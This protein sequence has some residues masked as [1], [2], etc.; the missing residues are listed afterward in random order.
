MWAELMRNGPGL[1]RSVGEIVG[2]LNQAAAMREAALAANR[3]Q[4]PL[5]IPPTPGAH[6]APAVT[7]MPPPATATPLPVHP[8]VTDAQIQSG[9]P[10]PQWVMMRVEQMINAGESPSFC[11]DWIDEQGVS[12]TIPPQLVMQAI[13]ELMIKNEAGA[14]AEI[15]D[16]IKKHLPMALP[17]MRAMSIE[18]LKTNATQD[19]PPVAALPHLDLLLAQF[20]MELHKPDA[21]PLVN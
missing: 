6:T 15:V 1:L 3:P 18:E 19:D 10:S 12:V 4:G 17:A 7:V 20:H 2:Q 13:R 11:L 16:L 21:V 9:A 8:H 14:A 5:I